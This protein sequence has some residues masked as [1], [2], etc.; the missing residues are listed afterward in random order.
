MFKKLLFLVVLFTASMSVS[1]QSFD[2]GNNTVQTTGW[3]SA[4]LEWSP[5]SWIVDGLVAPY[6]GYALGFSH[7]FAFSSTSPVLAEVGLAGQYTYYSDSETEDEAQLKERITLVSL[8]APLNLVYNLDFPNRPVALLPYVGV[9][10]RGNFWGEMKQWV[11][12]EPFGRY[13]D[14]FDKTE[15]GGKEN[16]WK[17]FQIGW[18]IGMKVRFSNRIII[19]AGYSADFNRLASNVK[20]RAGSISVGL[21]F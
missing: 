15:M 19:G 5:G 17:H 6:N 20:S 3:N 1:A 14:L 4:Y 18:Q 9:T 12:G 10:A 21:S 7:A 16:V 8:K 11:D 2:R 13:S